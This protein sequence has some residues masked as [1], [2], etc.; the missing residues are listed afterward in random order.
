MG[1]NDTNLPATDDAVPAD[2]MAATPLLE[3]LTPVA[4]RWRTVAGVTLLAGVLAFGA[5]CLLPPHFIA[6]ATFIPPTQ[7]N[8]AA[9]ASGRQKWR[10]AKTRRAARPSSSSVASTLASNPCSN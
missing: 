5:T 10:S 9:A 2:A 7:Q 6:T 1:T 8:S 4:R 3:V